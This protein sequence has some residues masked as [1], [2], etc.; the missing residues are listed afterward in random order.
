MHI[1]VRHQLRENLD[2][3]A[4]DEALAFEGRWYGWD[5]LRLF[6]RQLDAALSPLGLQAGT[7]VALIS[8]NRPQHVAAVVSLLAGAR[9]ACMIY[10][11]QSAAGLAN[12][13]RTL[14]A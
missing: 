7:S 2:T 1:D 4:A 12:E 10:G 8:R 14:R 9:T 13:V 11:S 5:W 3:C 6:H